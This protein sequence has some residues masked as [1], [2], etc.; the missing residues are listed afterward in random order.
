MGVQSLNGGCHGLFRLGPGKC[1]LDSELAVVHWKTVIN[2]A[3][4]DTN[5]IFKK[6]DLEL[7]NI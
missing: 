5:N 4:A 3:Y 1:R 7:T 2:R 6:F